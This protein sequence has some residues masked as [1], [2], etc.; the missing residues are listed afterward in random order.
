MTEIILGPVRFSINAPIGQA[1]QSNKQMMEKTAIKSFVVSVEFDGSSSNDRK[2][3]VTYT[4]WMDQ[5]YNVPNVMCSS[6]PPIIDFIAGKGSILSYLIY[7]VPHPKDS[8]GC[9]VWI[10]PF[11]SSVSLP[12]SPLIKRQKGGGVKGVRSDA[13][14]SVIASN[15]QPPECREKEISEEEAVVGRLL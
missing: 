9:V 5:Q 11:L 14:E 7:Y 2:Q 15:L 8:Q 12:S 6:T 13:E 4:V 10:F 1:K 3:D